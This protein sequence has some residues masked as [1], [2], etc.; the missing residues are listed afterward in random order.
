MR[1]PFVTKTVDYPERERLELMHTSVLTNIET[2]GKATQ[3]LAERP[4]A[5]IE[6]LQQEL[7]RVQKEYSEYKLDVRCA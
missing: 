2:L 7:C 4:A 1:R 5:I 3:Q 6:Q